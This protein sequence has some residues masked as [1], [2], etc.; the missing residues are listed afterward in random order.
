MLGGIFAPL[1]PW[2]RGPVHETM[3]ARLAMMRHAVPELTVSRLGGDAATLGAAGQVIH[4]IIADPWTH[5][6]TG[7]TGPGPR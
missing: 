2:I 1:F 7:R 6:A 5:V 3:T 4:R